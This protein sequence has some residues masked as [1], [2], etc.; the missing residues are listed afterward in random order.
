MAPKARLLASCDGAH[1]PP[2]SF[3][4]LRELH[5]MTPM[6]RRAPKFLV[7]AMDIGS[8]STRSALFDDLGRALPATAAS[9]EYAVRYGTDG[10]AELPPE[11]LL[12]ASRFCLQ[13]TLQTRRRSPS[14]RKIPIVAVGASAFW[15]SLL[16]LDGK[17]RPLTP[18]FTWADSRCT[19][20]A[21][22]LREELNEKEIHAQTG[23]MLRAS[24]WP[25]KLRWLRRTERRLFRK[26]VRWVSPAEWVF[27]EL[28]GAAGSSH[29]M[30]SAT[31]LYDL[32]MKQWHAGLCE[33]CGIEMRQLSALMETTAGRRS[34]TREIGD[35]TIFTAIGD[36]AAG[37]LGCGA[38]TEGHIAINIGTSAAVRTVDSA[39]AKPIPFGLFRYAIDHKRTVLGGAVSNAGN[40][41]RWCLRELRLGQNESKLEKALSRNA[42]ADDAITVLPFWVSER[43]PTWPENLAGAIVGLTQASDAAQILRTTTSAVFYRL[44][45]ILDLV[46]KATGSAKE[47]IVSG[48]ILHSPASVRLLADA[49]GRDLCVSSQA[50]ASLRGAAVYVLEKLGHKVAPLR[51][52]K[53]VRHDRALAKKHRKRREQQVALEKLLS[54][55]V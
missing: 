20:D 13:R 10:A 50:E 27:E 9:C 33:A 11:L 46:E 47:I 30:A 49:L 12:R 40:L 53:I 32:R 6:R 51:K 36:G 48:G 28:F 42:A 29:S 7:L 41:R 1:D 16:G 38:E 43:A 44:G 22:Q 35:A 37:N 34:A 4:A 18:V 39:A 31:G 24:F 3:S 55:N 45:E 52:A 2:K 19:A 17:G 21:A 54:Q 26:V 25:A 8:S 5:L 23:C 14:L 15:H